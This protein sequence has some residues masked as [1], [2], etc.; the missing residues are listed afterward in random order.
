LHLRKRNF[1]RTRTYDFFRKNFAIVFYLHAL[2]FAHRVD[3]N[4]HDD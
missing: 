4:A 1:L 3:A 2:T